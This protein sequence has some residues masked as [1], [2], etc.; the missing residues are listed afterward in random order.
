MCNV[1]GRDE[2]CVQILAGK[3]EGKRRVGRCRRRW[4]DN[5]KIGLKEIVC[6]LYS[7]SLRY[8]TLA[9]FCEHNEL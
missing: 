4:E 1:H 5:I 8:D 2:R 7:S 6:G 3:H 9:D